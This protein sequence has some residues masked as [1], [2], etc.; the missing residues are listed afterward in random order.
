[1]PGMECVRLVY[2]CVDYAMRLI[3]FV[4]VCVCVCERPCVRVFMQVPAS[5]LNSNDTDAMRN[6]II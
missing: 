5:E 1:M 4:N 2:M 3:E 6:S